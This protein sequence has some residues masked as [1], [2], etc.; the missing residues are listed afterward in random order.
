VRWFVTKQPPKPNLA[1]LDDARNTYAHEVQ[2]VGEKLD[3]MSTLNVGDLVR[4]NLSAPYQGPCYITPQMRSIDRYVGRIVSVLLYDQYPEGQRMRY[5]LDIDNEEHVYVPEWIEL[6][7]QAD[8]IPATQQPTPTNQP[9]ETMQEEDVEMVTTYDGE[10]HPLSQCVV[11]TAPSE[12]EGE[13]ALRDDLTECRVERQDVVVLDREYSDLIV[14]IESELYF[15]ADHEDEYVYCG[16]GRFEGQNIWYDNAVYADDVQEYYHESDVGNCIFW[17]DGPEVY[18]TEEPSESGCHD[19]HSGPRN[20]YTTAGT[21]FTI[22]FE[23]EKEDGDV[24]NRYELYEVDATG[25][26]R[27]R[28]GSLNDDTGYELVSPTYDLLSDRLDTDIAGSELL[29]DH[30]NADSTTSCGGHINFGKV[31]TSGSDLF[32][33]YASFMPLF[34]ALYRKRATSRW[35]RAYAKADKYLARDERYV[36]FNIKGEYIEFRIVSRVHDVATLLWRRDLF[37][38]MVKYPNATATDVQRMML[39][40]N[41]ELHKH[42]RKQYDEVKLLRIACWYSQFADAMYDSLQFSKTGQGVLMEFFVS[43]LK[44]VSKRISIRIEDI[45][46][47]A[48]AGYDLIRNLSDGK[49]YTDRVVKVSDK[50]LKFLASKA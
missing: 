20:T 13:Y 37:R 36:S 21:L 33:Q 31:G 39:N 30:I 28:D 7:A 32:K 9:Q 16:G 45:K 47:W 34:L 48:D 27:E 6:I 19:Y 2:Y 8:T 5:R 35:S 17:H 11:L 24:L 38:I 29:K 41:S 46:E 22:G 4:L 10:E 44:R 23:V 50:T 49:E 1:G 26:S 18:S 3:V 15:S 40:R 12:H 25:W 43:T 14:E 42:L